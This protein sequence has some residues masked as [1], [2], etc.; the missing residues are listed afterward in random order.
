LEAKVE[1]DYATAAEIIAAALPD[2][3]QEGS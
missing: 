1:A 3:A 2:R